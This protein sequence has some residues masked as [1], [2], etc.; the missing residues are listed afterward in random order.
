MNAFLMATAVALSPAAAADQP[1]PPTHEVRTGESLQL[2]R[3][4]RAG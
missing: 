1:A 4:V 3:A 2:D